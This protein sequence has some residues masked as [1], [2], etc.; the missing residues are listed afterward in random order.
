MKMYLRKSLRWVVLGFLI[1]RGDYRAL[2]PILGNTCSGGVSHISFEFS[3]KFVPLN[4]CHSSFSFEQYRP[5]IP[6]NSSRD[7]L[8]PWFPRLEGLEL[9]HVCCYLPKGREITSQRVGKESFLIHSPG[10]WRNAFGLLAHL[11][12]YETQNNMLSLS[13][14]Y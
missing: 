7:V 3:W 4:R 12:R 14:I 6:L 8:V 2:N 10:K 11:C 5:R 1:F 9:S 13:V